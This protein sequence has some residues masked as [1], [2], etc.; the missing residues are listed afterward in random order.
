MFFALFFSRF[1]R[2]Y[3]KNLQKKPLC[4]GLAGSGGRRVGHAE[5]T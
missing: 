1:N 3:A 2:L 5:T 4:S